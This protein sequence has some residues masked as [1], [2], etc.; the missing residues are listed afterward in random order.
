[1]KLE[2]N[3]PLVGVYGVTSVGKSTLLNA[4]LKNDILKVGLGET[5]KK[6]H[7]LQHVNNNDSYYLDDANIPVEQNLV[8]SEILESISLV[9]VPGTNKSFSAEDVESLV[10]KTDLVLWVFDL[11]GDI[12]KSDESFLKNTLL[13]NLIRTVVVINKVD[14]GA[15]DLYDDDERKEFINDVVNKK[16]KIER[17]FLENNSDFLLVDVFPLS[18]K[19]ISKSNEAIM[20]VIFRSITASA[21]LIAEEGVEI[22][23][24]YS[25]I[26]KE[27]IEAIDIQK[28]KAINIA[29]SEY[30]RYLDE[31][32]DCEIVTSGEEFLNSISNKVSDNLD[33]V[34]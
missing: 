15:E 34:T 12:S 3:K 17:F 16:N 11:H 10:D 14:S 18:A 7:L 32:S 2:K 26:E 24:H 28:N 30:K 8:N 21:L 9:D 4:F 25:K 22:K 19:E 1:M 13:K 33:F 20:D 6:I 23:N 27:M 29:S 31:T 5:T